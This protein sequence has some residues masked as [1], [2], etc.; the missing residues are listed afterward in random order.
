MVGWL[1]D[2]LVGTED[3]APG[4][5]GLGW[6]AGLGKMDLDAGRPLPWSWSPAKSLLSSSP[7][8]CWPPSH[9]LCS[10]HAQRRC[11]EVPRAQW[12]L[13]PSPLPL[14]CLLPAALPHS[15]ALPRPCQIRG[16]RCPCYVPTAPGR[17]PLQFLSSKCIHLGRTMRLYCAHHVLGVRWEVTLLRITQTSSHSSQRGG[18]GRHLVNKQN[19]AGRRITGRAA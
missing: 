16:N 6:Q 10:P 3:C 7:G 4:A 13:P 2:P 19:H 12:F 14:L 18:K 8:P 5:W 11:S 9:T 15:P 1:P 17:F